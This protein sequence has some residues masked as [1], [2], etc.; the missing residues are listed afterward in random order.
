MCVSVSEGVCWCECLGV[1]GCVSVRK[2]VC[3]CV[4]VCVG[5][6][7]DYRQNRALQV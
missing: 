4:R 6:E 7:H 1:F 3:V 2:G 5:V